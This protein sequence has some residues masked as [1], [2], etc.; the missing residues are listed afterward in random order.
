VDVPAWLHQQLIEEVDWFKKYLPSPDDKYFNPTYVSRF[1]PDAICW[2][3]ASAK[4]C[5]AHAWTLKALIEEAGLPMSVCHTRRPGSISYQDKYQIVA[6][7]FRS[8][9]P[10]FG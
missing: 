10:R 7:P 4:S 9:L 3:K 6:H 2:F 8:D 1:H 5:I